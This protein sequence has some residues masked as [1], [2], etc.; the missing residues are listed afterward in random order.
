MIGS[1]VWF[2]RLVES[3][4]RH[5]NLITKGEVVKEKLMREFGVILSKEQVDYLEQ[6]NI[7][8]ENK[9]GK[10]GIYRDDIIREGMLELLAYDLVEIEFCCH[11]IIPTDKGRRYLRR[12]DRIF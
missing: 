11:C 5:Y 6:L 12:V 8:Y 7:K 2:E 9:N 1:K 4:K 10:T 3:L